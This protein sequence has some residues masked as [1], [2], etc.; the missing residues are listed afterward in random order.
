MSDS[1]P[2]DDL[3]MQ[4]GVIQAVSASDPISSPAMA[5]SNPIMLSVLLFF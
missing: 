5:A 2:V 1:W 3:L 4:H